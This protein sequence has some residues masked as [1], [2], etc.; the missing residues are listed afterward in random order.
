MLAQHR[1]T[2][3]EDHQWCL[4]K[5][6]NIYLHSCLQCREVKVICF[7]GWKESWRCVLGLSYFSFLLC[8]NI[9]LILLWHAWIHVLIF[10]FCFGVSF[11]CQSLNMLFI[12]SF[13]FSLFFFLL[14]LVYVVRNWQRIVRAEI[15]KYPEEDNQHP[16]SAQSR[17]CSVQ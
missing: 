15:V 11:Y 8:V 9:L 14:H 10:F 17:V 7:S 1:V 2:D 6:M 3:I 16:S 5:K 12:L 4:S 13:S